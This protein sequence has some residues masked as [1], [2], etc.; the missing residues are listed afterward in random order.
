M[1]TKKDIGKFIRVKLNEPGVHNLKGSIGKLIRIF[2]YKNSR[3]ELTWYGEFKIINNPNWVIRNVSS[4]EDDY[5]SIK[6]NQLE[7]I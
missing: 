5:Y 4:F 1:I 3:L 6:L 7:L 2:S